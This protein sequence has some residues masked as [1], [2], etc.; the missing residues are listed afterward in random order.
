MRT[1]WKFVA[2]LVSRKPKADVIDEHLP[3]EIETPAL[4]Y[5]PAVEEDVGS[6]QSAS[7]EQAAEI[8]QANETEASSSTPDL[9]PQAPAETE[10]SGRELTATAP[11]VTTDDAVS[12]P[13]AGE[14]ANVADPALQDEPDRLVTA[15]ETARPNK[16]ARAN[17]KKLTVGKADANAS[18]PV[19]RHKTIAEEMAALDAEVSVLRR[20]LSVKLAEQNAQLR[21]MLER[22]ERS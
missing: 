9:T 5:R 18:V 14:G 7:S 12:K 20:Q 21:K 11:S 19:D 3:H 10:N 4:E 17:S 6:F 16:D 15:R 22:F 1:P 8:E 2:D 13:E